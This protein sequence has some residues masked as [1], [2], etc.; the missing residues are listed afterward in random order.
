MKLNLHCTTDPLPRK[1]FGEHS[2]PQARLQA[3][4]PNWNITNCKSVVFLSNSNVKPP[5]CT[6]VKTP[7]DDFL[8][9]VLQHKLPLDRAAGKDGIFP[10]HIF[11]AD[12]NS[13][14]YLSSL[15]NVSLGLENYRISRKLSFYQFVKTRSVTWV[16][17]GTKDLS[18]LQLSSPSCLNI[19]FFPASQ[20]F[21]QKRT[22]SLFSRHKL[23]LT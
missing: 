17:L 8:A 16:M 23:A 21:W 10:E 6:N 9:T 4:P 5:P 20:R 22:T 7:I 3:A 15:F 1:I 2:H 19:T 11:Y 12:S 14:N 18:L 13:C